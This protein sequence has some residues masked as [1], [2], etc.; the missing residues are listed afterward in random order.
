[1]IE[2]LH[3]TLRAL[4]RLSAEELESAAT[5]SLRR[6]CADAVRLELDCRQLELGPSARE[7]LEHV[8]DLLEPAEVRGAQLA[9]AIRAAAAVLG[10][11]ARDHPT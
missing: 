5:A 8:S 9:A 1:M 11:A 3:S 2:R 7:V 10:T 6:D 4:R